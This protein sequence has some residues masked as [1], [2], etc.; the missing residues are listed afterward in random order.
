MNNKFIF[1]LFLV[2]V[3]FSSCVSHKELINFNSEEE[4]LTLGTEEIVNAMNLTIQ[5]EDLLRIQVHS[6]D[7]DQKAA[8]PFNLDSP[9]QQQ[10]LLQQA[11]QSSGSGSNYTV[12]LFNGYL[13]DQEGFIYFP[14]IGKIAVEGLTIEEAKSKLIELLKKYINVPIVNMRFLNLKIT[15]LGEV[16]N[17]GTIRLSNKRVTLLEAIGMAGDLSI[18]ANRENILIIRE[19]NGERTTERLNL[20]TAEIFTSPY[21]YLQQ[22]DVIYV[23]P[24]KARIATV[25]DPVQRFI[26]YGSGIIAIVTLIIALSR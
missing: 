6:A 22:N 11:A 12:E 26:S 20:K 13:V 19:E 21:F 10:A 7:K 24:T 8:L 4:P 15:V 5:P 14:V 2:F 23:E 17:P 3:F 1:F 9:I 25:A 16:N 18:Y